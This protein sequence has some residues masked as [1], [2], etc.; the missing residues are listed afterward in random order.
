MDNQGDNRYSQKNNPTGDSGPSLGE[1]K[2][3][4]RL[5]RQ[6][7]ESFRVEHEN[8]V[9]E[10]KQINS[11]QCEALCREILQANKET[12]RLQQILENER[13]RISFGG[14]PET[15]GSTEADDTLSSLFS[16][17]LN[18]PI[19]TIHGR[20]M[21]KT[22]NYLSSSQRQS[23]RRDVLSRRAAIVLLG[24]FTLGLAIVGT[25]YQGV[26]TTEKTSIGVSESSLTQHRSNPVSGGRTSSLKDD[27]LSKN[28]KFRI[29]PIL[30]SKSNSASKN[31]PILKEESSGHRQQAVGMTVPNEERCCK[32]AKPAPLIAVEERLR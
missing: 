10:L 28:K 15:T 7:F 3:A 8:R 11:S 32:S 22:K 21:K 1:L 14:S 18:S 16:Q 2:E 31:S 30:T 9:Q 27:F 4:L 23:S 12:T 13:R 26:D 19:H 17:R 29:R 6:R 5:E 25:L 24:L 20:S